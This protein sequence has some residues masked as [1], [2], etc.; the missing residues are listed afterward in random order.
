MVHVVD[1]D[2]LA[3]HQPLGEELGDARLDVGHDLVAPVASAELGPD[4]VQIA[5]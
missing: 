2:H 4:R 3:S 5:L 1:R